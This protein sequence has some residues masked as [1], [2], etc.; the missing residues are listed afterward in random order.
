MEVNDKKTAERIAFFGARKM[1]EQG[2]TLEATRWAGVYDVRRPDGV[3]YGIKLPSVT[4]LGQKVAATCRCAFYR[5]NPQF[6]TCKHI[7]WAGW[8]A[9]AEAERQAQDDADAADSDRWT[10]RF[11][12]YD[13]DVEHPHVP[14]LGV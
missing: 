11:D 13:A 6:G 2:Y 7:V 9:A 8:S 5:A 14:G 3:A 10:A 1:T 12:E 4:R